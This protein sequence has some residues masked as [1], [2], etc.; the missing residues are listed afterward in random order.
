MY[1]Y[2]ICNVFFLISLILIKLKKIDN[3]NDKNGIYTL[4]CNIYKTNII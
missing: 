4:M 2:I 1:L 3:N